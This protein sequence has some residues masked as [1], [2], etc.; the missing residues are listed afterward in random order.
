[1]AYAPT[2]NATATYRSGL[3]ERV[4]MTPMVS[5]RPGQSAMRN[6]P[7]N[8]SLRAQLYTS[9]KRAGPRA[10]M[11]T[12]LVREVGRNRCLLLPLALRSR[13]TAPM[14]K[15]APASATVNTP[16]SRLMDV[17]G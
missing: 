17:T 14:A 11:T 13:P 2:V 9:I 1:M 5:A 4:T 3:A 16:G 8:M 15:P 7:P 6:G 10:S 12:K